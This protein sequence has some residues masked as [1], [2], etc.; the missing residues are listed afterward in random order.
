MTEFFARPVDDDRVR[1]E[2]VLGHRLFTADLPTVGLAD[3]VERF[4]SR[5]DG[6]EPGRVAA[7]RGTLE[8]MQIVGEA[9]PGLADRGDTIDVL[10]AVLWALAHGP[11]GRGWP[12][13]D[14]LGGQL[15]RAFPIPGLQGWTIDTC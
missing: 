13:L 12:A 9:V 4:E 2:M 10:W 5:L 1:V 8:G 14:D 11:Q 15:V 7:M 6:I 3:E